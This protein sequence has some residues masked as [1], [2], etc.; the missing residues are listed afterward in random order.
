MDFFGGGGGGGG[1]EGLGGG[2]DQ[3]EVI[4]G[5]EVF[6]EERCTCGGGGGRGW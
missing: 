4:E 5:V 3:V 2:V 1:C 6:D